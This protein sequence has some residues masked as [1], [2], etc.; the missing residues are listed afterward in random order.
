[1]RK[2]AALSKRSCL[3]DKT[4]E[5]RICGGKPTLQREVLH[6]KDKTKSRDDLVPDC[7][8]PLCIWLLSPDFNLIP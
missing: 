2:V 1:M 8:A 7:E 3:S 6:R 4:R 5:P